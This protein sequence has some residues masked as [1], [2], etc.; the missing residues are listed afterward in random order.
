MIG[1]SSL[2]IFIL[3]IGIMFVFLYLSITYSVEFVIPTAA[4]SQDDAIRIVEDDFRSRQ[5]EYDRITTIIAHKADRYV[6]I[7]E[8]RDRNLKL[9][10]IYV[11]SNGTLFDITESGYENLYQCDRGLTAYCGFLDPYFF[12]YRGRLVYGV[13]VHLWHGEVIGARGFPFL[14]IVDATSGEIVDSSFLRSESKA[15]SIEE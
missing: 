4:L 9:P 13:E 14:Y 6:P 2:F 10:L 5:S 7:N 11:H 15:R 1:E 12:D 8:F 3:V